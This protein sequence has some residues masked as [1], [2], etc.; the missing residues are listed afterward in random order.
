MRRLVICLCG[1]LLVLGACQSERRASIGPTRQRTYAQ[2][3]EGRW[4]S[5]GGPVAYTAV[6]QNGG[7]TSAETATNGLLAE[8]SYA[9][10]GAGQIQLNF[11]SVKRGV[12]VAANCN[13]GG[14]QM[15]CT[16]SDGSSFSLARV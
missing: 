15:T 5:M 7:F 8:G 4:A 10:T 1:T 12:K 11:T 2:G 9:N 16:S 13:Y 6:F 14:G 3:V